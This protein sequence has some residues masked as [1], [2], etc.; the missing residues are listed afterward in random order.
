MG[1]D[2]TILLIYQFITL[3]AA[4]ILIYHGFLSI[5]QYLKTKAKL[6]L[7]LALLCITS[8]TNCF[9][10]IAALYNKDGFTEVLLGNGLALG[11][12]MACILYFK[13]MSNFLGFRP[14]TLKYIEYYIILGIT[15]ITASIIIYLST[16]R[17]F[18]FELKPFLSK[19]IYIQGTGE[20]VSIT[21]YG[22]FII[23]SNVLLLSIVSF[24]FLRKI[25]TFKNPDKM[26]VVGIVSNILFMINDVLLAFPIIR[27]AFPLLFC[28]YFVEILRLSYL[29]QKESFLKIEALEGE[30]IQIGKVAELGYVA[31]NIAHDL[32]NPIALIKGS[33]HLLQKTL[34]KGQDLNNITSQKTQEQ[35]ASQKYIHKI[36][37]G[38]ERIEA[39]IQ[40]YLKMMYHENGETEE[41]NFSYLL[42]QAVNLC[43]TRLSKLGDEVLKIH[44]KDFKIN[45]YENQLVMSFVNLIS[46]ACEA[47]EHSHNRWIEISTITQGNIAFIIIKDSGKKIPEEVAKNLFKKG[48]TTKGKGNGTGLG[49]DFV[50]KV[51]INHHGNIHLDLK[52]QNTCFIIKLT[53]V[54]PISSEKAVS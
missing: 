20:Q 16:G 48:F 53:K 17:A 33:T 12:T 54:I 25:L 18:L 11:S 50:K 1:S 7:H 13:L 49:L 41:L 15:L 46:N 32:R 36:L 14:K 27:Y 30:V 28:S 21:A 23:C 29:S 42:E 8:S 24:L 5:F 43:S 4:S 3:N 10:A 37:N 52:N 39:I 47:I 44:L 35:I 51:L 22:L 45:G 31:G 40:T 2:Q 34:T 38:C 26:L 6:P 9:I 19:S